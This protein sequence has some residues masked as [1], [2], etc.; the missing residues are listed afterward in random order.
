MHTGRSLRRALVKYSDCRQRS[1]P[2]AVDLAIAAL[3][4]FPE[5][6]PKVVFAWRPS[7]LKA[8]STLCADMPNTIFQPFIPRRCRSLWRSRSWHWPVSS[9]SMRQQRLERPKLSRVGFWGFSLV[10][11]SQL[12]LTDHDANTFLSISPDQEKAEEP[13][14]RLSAS[15]SLSVGRYAV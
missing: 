11:R 9:P 15:S 4:R 7:S 8:S 1:P 13:M 14:D 2:V 5:T 3:N 10:W 6:W 12:S